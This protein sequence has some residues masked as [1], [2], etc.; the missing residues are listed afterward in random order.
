MY[1]SSE[2]EKQCHG[3]CSPGPLTAKKI[4]AIGKQTL[5]YNKSSPGWVFG[6]SKVSI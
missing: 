6:T 2:H 3:E 4:N 5:S 1:V